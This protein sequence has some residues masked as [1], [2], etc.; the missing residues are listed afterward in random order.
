MDLLG[1]NAVPIS[2]LK[3]V[4]LSGVGATN[5]DL[6]PDLQ[7]FQGRAG[8]LLVSVSG[9]SG[10]TPTLAITLQESSDNGN[11]DLFTATGNTVIGTGSNLLVP[12]TQFPTTSI[13]ANGNYWLDID[14]QYRK[15]YLKFIFTVAGTSPVFIVCAQLIIWR[16]SHLPDNAA[17]NYAFS[18][19]QPAT[20][21]GYL[22]I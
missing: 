16:L 6:N 11:T 1:Q 5:A 22:A 14:F 10:T 9:V 19:Y 7:L 4:T 21:L 3:P 15:R 2:I 12:Q 18:G 17:S 8:G 20:L 13:S